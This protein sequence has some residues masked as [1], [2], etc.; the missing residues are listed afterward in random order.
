MLFGDCHI[1]KPIGKKLSKS[2]KPRSERHC[3]R[4]SGKLGIF[5]CQTAHR[6]PETVRPCF[7][8]RHLTPPGNL[9]KALYAVKGSRTLFSGG[10]ALTLLCLYVNQHR[11]LHSFC[12]IHYRGQLF[13][14]MSV[15][16]AEVS[17]SE[18]LEYSRRNNHFSYPCF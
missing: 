11:L 13:Y 3:R 7:R 10:I 12:L 16:R 5:L 18:I 8:R 2:A 15:Y 9:I 1:K 17:E 14:I 4:H 6:L